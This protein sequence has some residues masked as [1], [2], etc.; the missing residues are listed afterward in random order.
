[1][2]TRYKMTSGRIDG[3]FTIEKD[4]GEK[5][6]YGTPP[7]PDF[8]SGYI[9]YY[10]GGFLRK[11]I[12]GDFSARFGNGTNLNTSIRTG[13]IINSAGFMPDRNAFRPYTSTDANKFLIGI[14]VET[15]THNLRVSFFYSRHKTV[16]TVKLKAD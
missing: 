13:Y 11:L 8:L 4:A 16:A 15:G 9:S 5:F 1:M 7:L 14:A 3:G 6:L 10:S 12:I 2:L